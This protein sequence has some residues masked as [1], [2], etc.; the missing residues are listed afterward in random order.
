MFALTATAQIQHGVVKTRG[1]LQEDGSV[2]PGSMVAEAVVTI[3]GGNNYVSDTEGR[4][5][6]AVPTSGRYRIASV[7]KSDYQLT[8]P[9]VL[10]REYELTDKRYAEQIA[11]T[12]RQALYPA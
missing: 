3:K 1:R 12:Y 2:K 11:R 8:D 6:F 5:K 9:D 4:F 10:T 7:T